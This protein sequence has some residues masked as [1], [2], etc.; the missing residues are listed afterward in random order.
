[1]AYDDRALAMAARMLAPKSRGGKGQE[2][3]LH[4]PAVAGGYDPLT[5]TTTPGTPAQDHLTSGVTD[6]FNTFLISQG[7]VEVDDVKLLLS[8]LK[9]DGTPTPEPDP[10]SWPLTMG[11]KPYTIIRVKPT[12][13]AGMNVLLELQLRA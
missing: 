8:P 5:E 13:P 11:G 7:I 4:Q 6:T 1:M 2:V 12:Q 3:T 9:A 10:A